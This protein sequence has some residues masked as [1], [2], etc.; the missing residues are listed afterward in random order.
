VAADEG[1][2]EERTED[3]G[4]GK[5]DRQNDMKAVASRDFDNGL[6]LLNVAMPST[7][8]TTTTTTTKTTTTT[9]GGNARVTI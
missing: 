1:E 7:T 5:K 3:R 6:E 8:T 4:E 9:A 2:E